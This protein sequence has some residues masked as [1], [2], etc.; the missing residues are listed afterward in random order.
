MVEVETWWGTHP[1]CTQIYWV[2]YIGS[3]LGLGVLV[4]CKRMGN[5]DTDFCNVHVLAGSLF[6]LDCL[7]RSSEPR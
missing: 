6:C 3:S 4:D 7:G 2:E 5:S 1:E